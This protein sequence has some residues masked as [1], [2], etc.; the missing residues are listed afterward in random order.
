[1]EDHVLRRTLALQHPQHVLMR[2]A[3]VDHHG[4]ADRLRDRD[5]PPERLA[6]RRPAVGR[7][8]EV[9]ESGLAERDDPR[10]GRQLGD[11]LPG[12]LVRRVRLVRVD[13]DRGPDVVAR[14]SNLDAPPR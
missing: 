8:T 6:L 12:G 3:V 14:R 7:R 2:L 1:M 11:G 4:L 13:R 9:V 10:M 5:V